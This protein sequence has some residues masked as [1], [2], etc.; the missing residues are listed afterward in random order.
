MASCFFINACNDASKT[1]NTITE[2]AAQNTVTQSPSITGSW[3]QP[4]P[5]NEKEVQG[6][7]LNADSSASSIN[8]ATLAYKKWWMSDGKLFLITESMG[9]KI[10]FMD[11][12][13]YDIVNQTDSSLEIKRGEYAEKYKKQ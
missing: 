6:F 7:T 10:S 2:N 4:N 11:T 1:N 3:V 8:M 5:I 12:A 13:A 9:N